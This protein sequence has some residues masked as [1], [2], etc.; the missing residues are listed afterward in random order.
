M[1]P[2]AVPSSRAQQVEV[3]KEQTSVVAVRTPQLVD[4]A[5]A[6]QGMDNVADFGPGRPMSP[7]QGYSQDPRVIDYPVGVNIST[8][9]RGAWGRMSFDTLNAIVDAYD[10]ARMCIN[11]KA[12]ELRSMEPLFLPKDGK[13]GQSG[14]VD[15]AIEAARVALEFPDRERPYDEWVSW[16]MENALRYDAVPLYHRRT[17]GGDVI[18]LEVLAGDTIA[19]LIDQHGRRP[20]PPAPAFYQ[21][22]KGLPWN[23]YTSQD[24]TYRRFRPQGDPYGLPPME[25]MLLTANTDIRF[26]WHFLQMF[27]DGSVPAGF[28]ELP[29][30]ISSPDQVAEWQDYWDAMMLGDQAKLH[31]LIAVP[32]GTKIQTGRPDSFDEAFPEYLMSRT[33]AAFGVTPQDLGLVKDVNRANGETQTDIQFRVNTLPW[34]NWINGILTRYLQRSLGLPVKV[35]LDTG[36]DKE[37]RKAEAE[38]WK[39]YVDMGAASP[40]EAR[41]E[42]LGLP[43]DNDRPVPRFVMTSRQGPVPLVSLLRIAGPIDPETAAPLDS[44]PLDSTPFSGVPGVSPDK[45]PGN[46]Q[47]KRAPIDPDEPRFPQLEKPVPGTD[48]VAPAA[49]GAPAAPVQKDAT[50]GVTS[51]SGIEGSPM[52]AVVETKPAEEYEQV[53]KAAELASYQRFV[54]AR[55]KAG[56]WRDFSFTTV[57]EVTAHRLNDRGRAE[58]RKAEGQFVAAGLVVQALDTGRVLMLQRA[59]DPDDD[60][61]GMWEFPGGHIEDGE[62]PLDGAVREW[63]EETGMVLPEGSQAGGWVSANGIYR[64]FVWRV[65]AESALD[66]QS[67]GAVSNPDDPDGDAIEALAWWDPTLLEDN[68]AVR[69]ELAA[70]LPAVLDAVKLEHVAKGDADPKG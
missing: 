38:A 37:D 60:A 11:H 6:A 42:L 16:L 57:D 55:R 27:T 26:Q 5:M 4:A 22:I 8:A 48:V 17:M 41:Q 54:K 59:N 2:P 58:V 47:F 32:N 24:I 40:D 10:V 36:R 50:A 30:G 56:R 70:S 3:T 63:G 13:A 69:R 67:R 34:V 33:C 64:G 12:D 65:P 45:L 18:G 14:L 52:A 19:P 1:R 51:A 62:S 28:I 44:V 39:L 49:G 53:V 66:L 9:E 7:A 21:R 15:E 23:F 29:E 43:I 46:P 68:P 25:S 61:A 31:Q 35:Q 20:R